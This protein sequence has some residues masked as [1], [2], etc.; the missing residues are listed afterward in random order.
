MARVGL[1]AT[2]VSAAGKGIARVQL[3]AVEALAAFGAPHELV[4]L[5]RS[6]E[7]ERQLASTGVEVHRTDHQFT[8]A[9]EQLHLPRLARKLGL[10]VIVTTSDRLPLFGRRSFVLWLFEV[11]T[12]RIAQNRRV[13]AGTYQR[14]TD[15]ATAR[16]W[17]R[18]VKSAAVVVTG[19]RA[20]ADELVQ[21]IAGLRLPTT[22][23]PGMDDAF[24]VGSS[25]DEGLYVFHLGSSDPR[26][27]TET[28][29]TAFALASER[30]PAETR[31]V[32][33]GGLGSRA[34]VLRDQAVALGLGDAVLFP[35]RVSD[36]RLIEL[37]RG[38]A[39]YVDPSLFEG[40]GYQ[41]LEAMACGAPVIASSMTSLP[42]LVGDAGI[43]CDATDAAAFAEALVL[44]L[45]DGMLADDLRERGFRQVSSFTWERT[46]KG[47]A[48]AIDQAL[49]S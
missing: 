21:R 16:L 41:V 4:A 1:D 46:A 43:L 18:S 47:L 17:K 37:Y 27:N 12:H 9:W 44:V 22:V 20:T 30:L 45:G 49:A 13:G 36:E 48:A 32:V 33:A 19:S 38:A 42:E 25:P 40:F 24:S 39:A 10:D 28:A 14:L 5:V 26:D 7:A 31:L 34:A 8:L 15:F 3:K 23:Y 29:L 6:E 11:P 35:G 2:S